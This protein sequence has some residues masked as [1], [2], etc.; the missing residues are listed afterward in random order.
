MSEPAFIPEYNKPDAPGISMNFDNSVS[1]YAI[2]SPEDSFE[3]AA[4][5]VFSMLKTAE[6]KYPGW[7]RI[8]FVDIAGHEG[9]RSGFSEDFFEFQQEFWF[10]AVAQFVTAFEL[11]IT[12]ALV[13]PEPQKNDLPDGLTVNP[14]AGTPSAT[15]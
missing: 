7:P 5:E 6:E 8:F 2:I 14:S 13:N 3:D 15:T 10:S 12:G 11:P 1:I 4:S 9:D